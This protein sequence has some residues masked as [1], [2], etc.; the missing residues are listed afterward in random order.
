MLTN[1]GIK[2]ILNLLIAVLFATIWN[3][4]ENDL[5][6]THLQRPPIKI[7]GARVAPVAHV[8]NPSY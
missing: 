5:I 7:T 6:L 1:V 4:Y 2:V 8:Y 3:Y